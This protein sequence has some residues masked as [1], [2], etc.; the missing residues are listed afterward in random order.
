MPLLAVPLVLLTTAGAC[1]PP[2]PPGWQAPSVEDLTVTPD[3][4]TAGSAFTVSALVSDDEAVG[5]VY[6]AVDDPRGRTSAA[7][8]CEVPAVDPE[9]VVLVEIPCTITDYALNGTWSVR[10]TAY[11]DEYAGGHGA[12]GVVART[13]FEVTGGSNDTTPPVLEFRSVDPPAPV[14]GQ[15][16]TVVVRASDEHL[17]TP[18]DEGYVLSQP[19]VGPT[20]VY[21]YC[22]LT[23]LEELSTTMQESTFTCPGAGEL[24]AGTYR[25]QHGL[26]DSNGNGASIRLDIEK[27]PAP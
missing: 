9:P 3:P 2:P 23:S 10:F 17:P 25:L 11:D 19:A 14:V 6:L 4:V 16:F 13:T 1:D 27:L 18:R 24:D 20:D 15:P 7:L 22:E 8:D 12:G 21:W 5:N 26:K